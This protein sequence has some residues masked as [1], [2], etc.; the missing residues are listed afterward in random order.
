MRAVDHIRPKVTIMSAE[1]I[2]AP[3]S[4]APVPRRGF[5]AR[6]P[7]TAFL[8]LALG[9]GLTMLTVPVVIGVD[10]SPFLLGMVFLGLLAPALIVTR[11]TDGPGGVRRL[12]ARSFDWR[13]GLGRWA[14]VLFALPLLTVGLAAV[15]GSLVTP[16]GGWIWMSGK[17]LFA[18]LIFGALVLNIWEETG[19]AGFL[20]TRLT[21][22]HGL[23]V[24]AL[25][26]AVPFGIIHIPLY[27]VGD[28]TWTEVATGLGLLFAIAPVYR[29]LIGMHMLDARGSVLAAGVQH[30]AWNASGNLSAVDGEWQVVTAVILLTAI[31]AAER[32]L[33]RSMR[34]TGRDAER[35]AAR[36]WMLPAARSRQG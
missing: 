13:F 32:P 31:M 17:Y 5:A 34:I 28:P 10:N 30:A 21:A 22:R 8:C 23:L 11:L 9:L 1:Q 35:E 33:S 24:A 12:L 20:Q 27:L 36:T 6:R 2:P 18:T 16:E 19:W 15:S 3:S 14:V 4:T 25:L 7:L 29:Y 26:T